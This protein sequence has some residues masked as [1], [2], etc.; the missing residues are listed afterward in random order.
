MDERD[1]SIK[2]GTNRGERWE[3]RGIDAEANH[4]FRM[5]AAVALGEMIRDGVIPNN[6]AMRESL[7]RYLMSFGIKGMDD[8]EELGIGSVYRYDFEA[9]FW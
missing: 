9:F 5:G 4:Y 2:N 8:V 1:G 6:S 3:K 7:K